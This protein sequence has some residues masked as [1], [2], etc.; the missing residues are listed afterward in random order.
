M[1]R[2]LGYTAITR[3]HMNEGH[4]SLLTLEL[5]DE[6]AHYAGRTAFTYADIE[7]V[8]KQCVFTTHTPVPAGHDQFPLPLVERLLGPRAAFHTMTHDLER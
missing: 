6:R 3:F 4:S 2:A 7:A 1:L 8:R 5:P